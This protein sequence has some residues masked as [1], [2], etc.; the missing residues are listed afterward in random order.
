[1]QLSIGYI[2]GRHE[3]HLDWILEGLEQQIQPGDEIQLVVID[4]RADDRD[5]YGAREAI[6]RRIEGATA[7]DAPMPL[8]V[9]IDAPKP[10]IWQGKHRVV[11]RDWWAKSNAI[12]TALCLAEHDYVAFLDDCCRLGPAWLDTVR[13]GALARASVL[14]GS[15]TKLELGQVV[16]DPRLKRA[17]HGSAGCGGGWLFGCTYAAPLDWL[18]D[19]NG[20]EE[21]MDGM[22][23]EDVVMGLMLHNAGYRIDYVPKMLVAQE[24]AV[25]SGPGQKL[26]FSAY[27]R[28]DKGTSPKDKSHAALARFGQRRR[29]ELT[30]DLT[31]LRARIAAG[32]SFES[33]VEPPDGFR[34]WYDGQLIREMG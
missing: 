6:H 14:A 17:P 16:L 20:A 33:P 24:R 8:Q 10:T 27:A 25:I 11:S 31:E 7:A 23:M 18:L 9:V 15:Y 28:T 12:N 2:T 30:P 13:A 4:G 19:V 21:G 26:D 3:P 29:T 32:G 34:D 22:G 5:V 1:M